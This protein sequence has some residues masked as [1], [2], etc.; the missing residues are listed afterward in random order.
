MA[1]PLMSNL[2]ESPNHVLYGERVKITATVSSSEALDSVILHVDGID[3]LMFQTSTSNQYA[4]S[5][6]TI[7]NLAALGFA[8]YPYT[9][10]ATD[11]SG[12][13]GSVDGSIEVILTT[14]GDDPTPLSASTI[15]Q[16][17]NWVRQW[18]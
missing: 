18:L 15:D 16:L 10:T 8:V 9:I 2:Q 17:L 1:Q 12:N 14:L 6:H 5:L 3:Y 7:D 4:V 13:S 11:V